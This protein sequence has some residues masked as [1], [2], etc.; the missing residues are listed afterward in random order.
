MFFLIINSNNSNK[1]KTQIDYGYLYL[2][3]CQYLF[4]IFFLNGKFENRNII[5]ILTSFIACLIGNKIN[6]YVDQD[7]FL[8]L[9]NAM[10]F[11]SATI[12]IMSNFK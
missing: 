12:V 2:A 6:K 8:L 3:S 5:L 1:I 10:I 4:L 9:L 7:K 11:I